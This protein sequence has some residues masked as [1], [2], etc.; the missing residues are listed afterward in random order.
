[1]SDFDIQ[2]AV[3][4]WIHQHGDQAITRARE[5]VEKMQRQGDAEG[6]DMWLRIIVVIGKLGEPPIGAKH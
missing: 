3:G 5:M 1:M 2:L 4:H 6:V